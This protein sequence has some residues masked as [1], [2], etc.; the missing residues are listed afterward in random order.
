M[1]KLNH[2]NDE[3]WFIDTCE[4]DDCNGCAR[5]IQLKW[6]FDNSGLPKAKYKPF[7]LTPPDCDYDAFKRLAY[8]KSDIGNFVEDGSNLYLCSN[9]TGNGKTSWAIKM[10][11]SYLNL[12]ADGNYEHLMGMYIS[13]SNL[14]LH[15]KDFNNPVSKAFK[16]NL[17][18]V[19]LVVWDDIAISGLSNYD[20]QQ[21][22]SIIDSRILSE[23]ANIFTCNHTTLEGLAKVLGNRLASR[24]YNTSEIIELKG[25]DRR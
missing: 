6:Q 8:I 24:I 21:L 9:Y 11:Q 17:E 25:G 5:Y 16:D 20:Y 13:T 15:L 4:R 22:Y 1:E 7:R 19:D 23:K 3:C 10:L 2:S 12:M 18:T 14:L